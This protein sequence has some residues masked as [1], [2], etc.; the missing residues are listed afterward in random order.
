MGEYSLTHLLPSASLWC[1]SHFR[2][3]FFSGRGRL[4]AAPPPRAHWL[5]I[6]CGEGISPQELVPELIRYAQARGLCVEHDGVLGRLRL[7]HPPVAAACGKVSSLADAR[8]RREC[9]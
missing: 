4:A 8:R 1:R 2:H 3:F 5:E 7:Y 9:R 6:G